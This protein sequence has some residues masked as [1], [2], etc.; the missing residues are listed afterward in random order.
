MI[1][2]ESRAGD[3]IAYAPGWQRLWLTW[4]LEHEAEPGAYL[5]VDFAVA[6]EPEEVDDLYPHEVSRETL[7]GR[8]RRH[9]RIWLVKRRDS[10]P[11]G[12]LFRA[13]LPILRSEYR[14][15]R[16]SDFG[17]IPVDLYERK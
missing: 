13:A 8:L 9:P 5:P 17:D 7:T 15:I 4:H 11:S 3:G 14:L 10:D 12:P 2:T 1:A 6:A 16:S